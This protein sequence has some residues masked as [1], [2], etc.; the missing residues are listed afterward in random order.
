MKINHTAEAA[1]KKHG[2]NSFHSSSLPI[3]CEKDFV[4]AYNDDEN[5]TV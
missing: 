1:W 3:F 5:R 4:F 2:R